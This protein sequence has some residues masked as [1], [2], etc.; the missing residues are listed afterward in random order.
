M[1]KGKY[2]FAQLIEFLNYDKF[3]CLVDKY[4]GN[5]YVKHL[6]CRNQLL[7]LMFGH[8]SNRESQRDLIVALG[9]NA[10]RIQ[11]SAAITAF[12]LVAIILYNMQLKRS[13]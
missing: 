10:V 8:F 11:I 1:N 5:G 7:A 12:C 4:N 3:R 9:A 2:V 6:P 13:T